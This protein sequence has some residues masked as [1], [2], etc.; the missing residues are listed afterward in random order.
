MI[1]EVHTFDWRG[2]TTRKH[3]CSFKMAD[4]PDVIRMPGHWNG[5]EL[6]PDR[7]F[8]S[9]WQHDWYTSVIYDEV[10]VA[11]LGQVDHSYGE[12][13]TNPEQ[14]LVE[15]PGRFPIGVFYT[16][17]PRY[18]PCFRIDKQLYNFQS[19]RKEH[20]AWVGSAKKFTPPFIY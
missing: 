4:P 8:V 15:I 9:K 14:M 7:I 5:I 1:C 3:T 10:E 19:F 17:L 2:A 13:P 6:G 11:I 20:G 16:D 12:L 18:L